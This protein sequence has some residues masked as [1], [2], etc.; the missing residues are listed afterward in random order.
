MH[1]AFHSTQISTKQNII[2]RPSFNRTSPPP[3][4]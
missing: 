4:C 2:D 1:F 3:A